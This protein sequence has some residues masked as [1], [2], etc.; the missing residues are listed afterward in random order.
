MRKERS[1]LIADVSRP[2][3]N[4]LEALCSVEGTT[5]SQKITDLIMDE[6][7]Q[8]KITGLNGKT[9]IFAGPVVAVGGGRGR[10]R[11][12]KKAIGVKRKQML[13]Q[14]KRKRKALNIPTFH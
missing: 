11:G 2:I 8:K 10:G 9:I 3:R 6:I 4:Q 13:L 1:R 7:C 12:K 14:R 5:I